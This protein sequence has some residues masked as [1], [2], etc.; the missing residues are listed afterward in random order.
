MNVCSK[1]AFLMFIEVINIWPAITSVSNEKIIL[2]PP[3]QK[4]LIAYVLQYLSSRIASVSAS[5]STSRSWIIRVWF[6]LPG[7]NSKHFCI[8]ALAI[9][10]SL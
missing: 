7:T 1:Y 9:Q 3:E 10:E 4:N 2:P 5:N 8:R 6:Y